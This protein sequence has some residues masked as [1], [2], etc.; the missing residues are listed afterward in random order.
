MTIRQTYA[1]SAQCALA[2]LPIHM[3]PLAKRTSTFVSLLLFSA[4]TSLQGLS[5]AQTLPSASV[6]ANEQ[7]IKGWEQLKEQSLRYTRD[8]DP[9]RVAFTKAS[10]LSPTFVEPLLG[11]GCLAM[12]EGNIDEALRFYTKSIQIQPTAY[13][14]FFRGFVYQKKKRFST[15]QEDYFALFSSSPDLSM[16]GLYTVAEATGDAAGK[17]MY[18]SK[19]RSITGQESKVSPGCINIGRFK[20][21][22]PAQAQVK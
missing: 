15:A 18:M 4:I 20:I 7:N 21:A 17:E 22:N 5:Y 2:P 16:V 10:E 13:A 8:Y 14:L 6:L 12:I 3:S 9:A 1:K 19:Y 11:L